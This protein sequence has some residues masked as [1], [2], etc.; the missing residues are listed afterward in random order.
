MLL[1]CA[2]AAT[3][4]A[5][6]P[7]FLEF[8]N[9]PPV[10]QPIVEVPRLAVGV[11]DA[12]HAAVV[13]TG[14]TGVVLSASSIA[15][16]GALPS[17]GPASLTY[18]SSGRIMVGRWVVTPLTIAGRNSRVTTRPIPVLAVERIDC[19]PRARRCAPVS[20]PDNVAM[21]GIGFARAYDHQPDGTPDHNP[22]LNLAAAG[23][24]SYRLT[25]HGIELG[26]GHEGFALVPLA[27]DAEHGDWAAA[28]ACITLGDGA[29]SCG[30]L[31]VDTGITGMFLTLPPEKLPAGAGDATALPDGTAVGIEIAP[32]SAGHARIGYTIHAGDRG[33]D[34]VPSSITL[35]GIGRRPTFVNTGV[36]LLNRFDYLYDAD[37][38]VIGFRAV[39]MK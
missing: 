26:A 8:L 17:L 5:A 4:Q 30:K 35:A 37:A 12:L 16:I 25:R 36:H 24:R 22:L 38:G 32:A 14:S 1:P 18:S 9:A 34:A 28:G 10:G 21:L 11:G 19:T 15:G 39:A 2:T 31:L 29:P 6:P 33:D 27:R 20:H 3:A 23:P 7:V 13:D